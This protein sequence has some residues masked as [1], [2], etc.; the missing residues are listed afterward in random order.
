MTES[1]H[2]TTIRMTKNLHKAARIKAL[3]MDTTLSDVVREF[4]T[5][6]VAGELE[7]PT[8]TEEERQEDK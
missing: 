8:Q 3:E 5:L 2:R 7:L 6:W 1:H 4:L